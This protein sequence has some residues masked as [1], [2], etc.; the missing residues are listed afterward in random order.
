MPSKTTVRIADQS[1]L[2]SVLDMLWEMHLEAGMGS[3]NTDK[4]QNKVYDTFKNGLIIISENEKKELTG[5]IGLNKFQFWWSDDWALAD[6]WSF[7]KKNHRKSKA[8][9]YLV[10]KAKKI[11]TEGNVPLLLA[12][13]GTVDEARKTKLFSRIGVKMGTTV[14]MGDISRFLW[15]K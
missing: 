8:F 11:A 14:I 15:R 10:K 1:D 6:Q 3:L 9:F 12:N 7:V 5:T 4:V 13:F 2:N